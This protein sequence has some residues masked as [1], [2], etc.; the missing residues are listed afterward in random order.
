MNNQK[1][2]AVIIGAT[3]LIGSQLLH[4]LLEDNYFG[5]VKIIG[6]REVAV[7][8]DKLSASVIDFADKEAYRNALSGSDIIF[9]AI[10]TTQQKVKGDQTAYRKIDFDIPV[11][12]ARLGARESVSQMLLVSSVGANRE[13]KNFYLR[14]KGEVEESII[15]SGPSSIS[16]FRPSMLLGDRKEFRLAEKIVQPVM[17]TLS[18]LI[19]AKYKPIHAHDVAKSMIA[20]SKRVAKGANIYHYSEMV[21]LIK[22]ELSNGRSV[23]Q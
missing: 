22:S 2:S 18:F 19:P 16:I 3:G 15:Q 12:A 11:N 14:L 20:A 7:K 6:R 4:L 17:K 5:H 21:R 8:H 9:C 13:S 10:G 1:H 23:K